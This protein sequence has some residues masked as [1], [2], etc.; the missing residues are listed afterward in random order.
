M[1]VAAICTILQEEEEG[2]K[3]APSNFVPTITESSERYASKL[4]LGIMTSNL[5][6]RLCTCKVMLV[7]ISA[8][9]CI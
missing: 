2:F 4:K 5:C 6:N 9:A 7:I 8:H 3:M 1:I